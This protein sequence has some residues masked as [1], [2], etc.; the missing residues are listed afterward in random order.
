MADA[1][2]LAESVSGGRGTP[3]AIGRFFEELARRRPLVV[4]FDDIHWG[5]RTFLDLVETLAA[6]SCDAPILLL[7]M[8]RPDLLEL[9]PAWGERASGATRLLLA[10]LSEDASERLVTN[11]LGPSEFLSDVRRRITAATEG[12]PLFVEEVVAML[13]DEGSIQDGSPISLPPTIQALLGARLDRLA[14][15]DRAVLERGSVEGKAFHLGAVVE[16]SPAA[17]RPQVEERL[18]RLLEREFLEPSRPGFV[19]ERAYRFHHQLLRDVAYESLPKAA[20]SELHERFANWLEAKAADRAQEF[21][22]ILGHHLQLAYAYKSDLGPVDEHGLEL[23]T[24]AAG[25]LGSAGT[26]AYARGDMAGTGNLLA[27]ALM[28][29]PKDALAREELVR[30]LDDA[31]FELGEWRPR[32]MSRASLRCYW[33]R[34]FGHSWEFK[35]SGGRPMLRCAAC[36]KASR[37]PRGWVDRRDDPDPARQRTVYRG[38]AAGGDPGG[39]GGGGD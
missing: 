25:H 9:R 36:G 15:E 2:G 35:E 24:Q 3:W 7:C 13:V 11:L 33:S 39:D 19:G 31:R 18:S 23:A 37:G 22:E 17:E 16:L 28:L 32:R 6:K 1:V 29:L 27:R 14:R 12:N 10:P 38:A 21:D 5:E 4:V 26:R 34:P 30:Q 8:A 20:R